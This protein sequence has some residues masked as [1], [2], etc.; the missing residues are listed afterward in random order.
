MKRVL[1]AATLVASAAVGT[2]TTAAAADPSTDELVISEY[3]EGSSFNK[4]IELY[5][6]TGSPL[7]LD[8]FEFRLYSNGRTLAE[9]PNATY[10]FPAVDLADGDVFVVTHPSFNDDEGFT[11]G[12]DVD[13]TSGAINFNGNDAFT[14]VDGGG[15]V[16]DSFGQVGDDTGFAANV[17]LRRTD[18][19][20]DVEP[21]DEFDPDDQYASFGSNDVSDLGLAPSGGGG[22]GS[23][24]VCDTPDEE[25]TLIS[26][27]QGSGADPDARF[28]SPLDGQTVT[29][30]AVVT[31]ADAD[32]AGYFVQEEPG[33]SDSDLTSSE[34][35][36][37]FQSA[38]TL[39]VEGDTVELTDEVTAFFG[40]TQF[41]FPDTEV[42]DV[43]PIAI[44]PTPLSLP[45]DRDG[46]EALESMLVTNAQDLQVTGL[47]TAYRFG[48]L[49]LAL[50]GP[51]TQATSAFAPDD[52]A[53]AALEAANLSNE[54]KVND[55]DEAFSDFNPYPW[56]LFDEDLSAGDTMPAGRLVGA[57]GYSFGEFKVEPVDNEIGDPSDRI[58]FPETD[59][60]VP[61][62]ATPSLA[63]GNDIA[64]FN[65]L[66]YFNTFG[67]SE[68][69]RGATNQADFEVQTAKLVDAINSLDAAVVG[70][71]EI[72][73]DYE[74]FYDG[75]PATVPSIVTLVDALNAAAGFDKWSYVQPPQSILTLEGL[76][77]GGLGTDA[78]ANG[79]IY[80]GARTS[81]VLPATTFDIDALLTG[82]SENSRWPIAQAFDIDNNRVTVVV[83]HFKS[84]GSSCDDTAGPDYAL[85]EDDGSTLAGNCDLTRQ[86]A[87]ERLVEWVETK[88]NPVFA[89]RKVFLV[90]DFNSY[91]EETP[92]EILVDAGYVDMVEAQGGDAFTYKFSGRYGRLDY[93][94]ASSKIARKVSDTE[95]WQI[96]SIAPT[97]YAY[98]NDPID[99]SAHGSSDHDPVVVSLK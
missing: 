97:G 1:L 33:D 91:E 64:T 16:V 83:N 88:G 74:D 40:L 23:G 50:D 70:L 9:G 44:A 49:G 60:T 67:S 76:G 71:I 53:A 13:D 98:F 29:I 42:C 54:L 14:I 69:L 37:V 25:L 32:L 62:P 87:A 34:G 73:N 47:F 20:R 11:L 78:I 63:D 46:R 59:D 27:I 72:E 85:G 39:P 21:T 43:D 15:D 84:K 3:V 5:N 18:F 77:G 75:D 65:V 45:L 31:L 36:F 80:Q 28:D 55:R 17:T 10:S 4:A 96:N 6:G 48:E 95:V 19:T 81:T 38:G 86:Y 51:L 41:S 57:L 56:E 8:G 61:V 7:S 82:D 35:L 12:G 52:P 24:P 92:I 90:G 93:V 30:R 26:E 66:N 68:V 2:A 99:E 58:F 94:F 79:I 22:G 89:N